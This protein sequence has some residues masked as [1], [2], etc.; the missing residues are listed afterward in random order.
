M[1]A[2]ETYFI[3]SRCLAGAVISHTS[4]SLVSPGI[5]VT[6]TRRRYPSIASGRFEPVTR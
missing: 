2:R 5:G 3:G 4:G 6:G 1:S